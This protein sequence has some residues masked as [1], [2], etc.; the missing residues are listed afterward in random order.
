MQKDIQR[1]DTGRHGKQRPALPTGS[2]ALTGVRL[3]IPP[4]VPH[5]APMP[6]TIRPYLR[7]PVQCAVTYHASIFQNQGIVGN[8][9]CSGW[10][11]PGDR[12]MRPG[13]I[14]ALTVTLPNEQRIEIPELLS[15]GRED[16]RLQ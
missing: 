13:K 6:F 5:D 9:S 12:P 3:H 15:C 16:R 11:L 2:S 7:F 10:R 8:V 1:R 4:S 14:P